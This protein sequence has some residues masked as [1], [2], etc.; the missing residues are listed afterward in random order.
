MA[1]QAS[2]HSLHPIMSFDGSDSESCGTPV[3]GTW[4]EVDRGDPLTLRVGLTLKADSVDSMCVCNE[5][6]VVKTG[7]VIATFD[8]ALKCVGWFAGTGEFGDTDDYWEKAYGESA[9]DSTSTADAYTED[10][11]FGSDFHCLSACQTTGNACVG[12][13][14][15][16][17]HLDG[18]RASV[19]EY[20]VPRGRAVCAV[21]EGHLREPVAVHANARYIA[22]LDVPPHHTPQGVQGVMHLFAADTA[23]RPLLRTLCSPDFLHC[24]HVRL[25]PNDP[26]AVATAC[27]DGD[28]IQWHSVTTGARLH[29]MEHGLADARGFM[30]T[31]ND[32]LACDS[33]AE[34]SPPDVLVL[35]FWRGVT[36]LD[37]A[38]GRVT[39]R[40]DESLKPMAVDYSPHVGLVV[41]YG[42]AEALSVFPTVG[43]GG[44]SVAVYQPM[45]RK[46]A[47]A[48]RANTA[49]SA[50]RLLAATPEW[51]PEDCPELVAIIEGR[52]AV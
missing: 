29:V 47:R 38:T 22:V 20:V 52:A 5:F 23:L 41:M 39:S 13:S 19:T 33:L 43:W 44:G 42:T 12:G 21:G 18:A 31:F 48:P 51:G 11:D 25:S 32:T 15:T 30:E 34:P 45:R 35:D 26:D 16:V 28:C 9:E 1:G 2:Q 17:L 7:R 6:V 24:V 27:D 37:V 3:C 49:A 50:R 40:H 8:A 14:D 10:M 4:L 46:C 36:T